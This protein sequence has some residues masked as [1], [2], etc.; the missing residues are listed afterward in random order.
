MAILRGH[1]TIKL[2]PPIG[3]HI[4]H[5][6]KRDDNFFLFADEFAALASGFMMD[7]YPAADDWTKFGQGFPKHAYVEYRRNLESGR[8]EDIE[9]F[10][11]HID[12]LTRYVIRFIDANSRY[13][14]ISA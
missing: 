8:Q 3:R 11:R 1:A 12:A 5:D 4:A 6:I 10:A 2:V 9:A 7:A 14:A 13:V